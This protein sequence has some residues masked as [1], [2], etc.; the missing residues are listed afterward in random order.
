LSCASEVSR[1][2]EL[3]VKDTLDDLPN[4]S[5]GKFAAVFYVVSTDEFYFCDGSEFILGDLSVISPWEGFAAAAPLSR[6]GV[7]VAG[8]TL[9]EHT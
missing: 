9:G 5:N 6:W 4:C 8:K 1:E 7:S 2:S 3:L